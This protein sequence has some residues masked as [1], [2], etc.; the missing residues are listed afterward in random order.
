MHCET[1]FDSGPHHSSCCDLDSA[2][3]FDDI[4]ADDKVL[5]KTRNSE[6][7][8]SMIDPERRKGTLSGGSLGD[9]SREAFLIESHIMN[10]D[11]VLHDFSGL[12]IGGRALFYVSSGRSIER[13]TT[14]I[15]SGLTLV[16]AADR[17]SLIS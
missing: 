10:E 3:T 12:K 15:V 17:A 4:K 16:R 7:R 11:G 2:L 14:S 6:Y 9:E 8:F 1:T 13:V 5:I